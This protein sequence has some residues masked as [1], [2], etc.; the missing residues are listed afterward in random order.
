[1][2]AN[3]FSY[4]AALT[5]RNERTLRVSVVEGM[6]LVAAMVGPFLSKLMKH[7]L[8]TSAVFMGR[9]QNSSLGARQFNGILFLAS[10]VCY[11]V[12][13]VYCLTL[14]EPTKPAEREKPTFS[15]LF[16]PVHLI[17]SMK[18]IFIRRE[19][20]GRS[21]LLITLGSLFVVQ[22]VISG[23]SDILYI[24]LTN[25]N[26]AQVFDYFFGFKNLVGAIGLILILPMLKRCRI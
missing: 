3:C 12:Q 1:M 14:K 10:G 23:E 26:S 4:V 18:T 6:Q 15:R 8:G 22:N 11:V 7:H 17:N 19:N 13:L 2:I 21:C 9:N 24:F 16:S 25:I 20:R 5:D